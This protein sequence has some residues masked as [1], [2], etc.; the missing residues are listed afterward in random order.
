MCIHPPCVGDS[1]RRGR[2]VID[3]LGN[4]GTLLIF[5]AFGMSIHHSALLSLHQIPIGTGTCLFSHCSCPGRV[6]YTPTCN[7]KPKLSIRPYCKRTRGNSW[8]G[9]CVLSN[10]PFGIVAFGTTS[11][12]VAWCRW[13]ALCCERCR[14]EVARA[15]LEINFAAQTS[16]QLPCRYCPRRTS[17]KVD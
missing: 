13:E 10:I 6:T 17:F 16:Q 12:G 9:D 11:F 3:F 8:I 15:P 4:G 1:S 5:A 2:L 14:G 7:T